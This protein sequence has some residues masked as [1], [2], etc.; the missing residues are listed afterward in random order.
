M[1]PRSAPASTFGT[2]AND[3]FVDGYTEPGGGAEGFL[4]QGLAA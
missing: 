4:V 3:E 2:G 1:A